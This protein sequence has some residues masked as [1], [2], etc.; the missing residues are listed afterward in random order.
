MYGKGIFIGGIVG[1]GEWFKSS[2]LLSIPLI[3]VSCSLFFP[4]FSTNIKQYH[5]GIGTGIV[6]GFIII[7]SGSF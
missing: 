7:F 4:I 1:L 6:L 5:I 2:I 3:F